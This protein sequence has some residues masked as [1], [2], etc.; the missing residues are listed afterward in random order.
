MQYNLEKQKNQQQQCT[1]HLDPY[2][3]LEYVALYLQ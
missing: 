3:F 2:S 1:V